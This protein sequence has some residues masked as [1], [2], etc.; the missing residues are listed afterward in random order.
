MKVYKNECPASQ[1]KS[2]T[3]Q[4]LGVSGT[5]GAGLSKVPELVRQT[6]EIV[7]KLELP[8]E[9]FTVLS[10]K[11]S[12]QLWEAEGFKVAELDD[13][14]IHLFNNA[15]LDFLKG[16]NLIVAGRFERPQSYYEDLWFDYEGEGELYRQWQG[17]SANGITNKVFS[18][19]QKV[20]HEKWVEDINF[21]TT[22]AVGRSRG[23]RYPTLNLIMNNVPNPEADCYVRDLL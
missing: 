15:G 2:L 18:Y 7:D 3:I 12:K 19:N 21:I 20:I 17:A 5:K 16:K 11:G 22:Q 8:R 13:E 6:A 14:E 1:N 9:M 10:F 4:F 23:K